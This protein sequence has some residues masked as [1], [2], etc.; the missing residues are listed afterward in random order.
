MVVIDEPDLFQT[1]MLQFRQCLRHDFVPSG[2]VHEQL[3]FGLRSLG[4]RGVASSLDHG[5]I[6]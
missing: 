5:G 4:D 1:V 6:R 2:F 3:H